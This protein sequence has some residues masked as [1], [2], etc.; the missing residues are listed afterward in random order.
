[1]REIGRER[2]REGKSQS[3]ANLKHDQLENLNL[4][5]YDESRSFF[6]RYQ[7]ANSQRSVKM[8]DAHFEAG[9]VSA[10]VN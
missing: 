9:R 7:L 10:S 3:D 2:E 4:Q 5:K 1:M 6:H 8:M